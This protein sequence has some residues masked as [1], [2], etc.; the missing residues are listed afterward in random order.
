M[1]FLSCFAEPLLK[2]GNYGFRSAEILLTWVPTGSFGKGK[3]PRANLMV[4]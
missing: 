3:L 4:R 1:T 2:I